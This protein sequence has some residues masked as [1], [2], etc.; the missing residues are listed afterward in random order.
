MMDLSEIL[1]VAFI[2]SVIYFLTHRWWRHRQAAKLADKLLQ[3]V[4]KGK[5]SFRR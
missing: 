1:I 4:V 5:D 2:V 3:E